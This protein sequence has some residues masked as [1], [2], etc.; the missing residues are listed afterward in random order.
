M[1]NAISSISRVA[2][3][4]LLTSIVTFVS[5]NGQEQTVG[6]FLNDSTAFNG[7]TLFAPLQYTTTYLID[8]N[9]LLVHSWGSNF[10]P[11][12]SV[13]LLESG[14]LLRTGMLQ[15]QTFT[16]GGAGG[17]VQEFDWEGNLLWD[18]EYANSQY[19]QH[20]D[21]E[22]LPNGNVLLIA[23]EYKTAAEAITAG[24]DP[25][26]LK[27]GELWPDHI[28]EVEPDGVSGGNIVWEWHVWDHLIQDQDSTKENYGVVADHPELVD[29]NFVT[30]FGPAQGRADWTHVNSIDYDEEFDQI[31]LSVP[32]FSEIWVLDHSTSTAEAAGHTGGNSGKGGDILYRW[33]NP[34]AYRAGNTGDRK[35]FSQHDAQWIET[36]LPGAGNILIFNNGNGRGGPGGNYSS[37]DEIVPPVDENGNY[38]LIPGAAY[39]PAEAVWSYTAESPA[40]F[41]AN[42]ISGAQRLPN[43]NTLIC[44]GPSGI[45]FE[46]TSEGETVW[47]YINPVTDEGPLTQGNPI[48][49]GQN[50]LT[51]QVFRSY[52]Y[53]PDYSGLDG[54]DLTPRDP[55]ELY[56]P[57][58]GTKGDVNDD[59]QINVLDVVKLVC[60]ILN[61]CEYDE[62]MFVRAD[63][64]EDG[65]VNVL[66]AVGIVQYILGEEPQRSIEISRVK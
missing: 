60:I 35:L 12:N 51:N 53:A 37:V 44:D 33:G 43:G 39:G 57:E 28:I 29:I 49:E 19:L 11:G 13:Y 52:R 21:I 18:F 38:P 23:W 25:A 42:H 47:K 64:N 40:D 58:E 41:F 20:H 6:L 50:G 61:T 1:K 55:I 36:G 3:T 15:N 14:H 10:F 8:N 32:R 34:Q 45:F 24:R 59:G 26:L 30:S 22:W 62:A 7:Y 5:L 66:D 2:I 17:L 9:G 56:P 54:R 27:D 48:P 4:A 65:Q 63:W 16:A 46:V 31:L